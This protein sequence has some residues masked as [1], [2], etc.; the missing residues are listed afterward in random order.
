MVNILQIIFNFNN[1]YYKIIKLEQIS[2]WLVEGRYSY[3]IEN[4]LE[5]SSSNRIEIDFNVISPI[6]EGTYNVY[7]ATFDQVKN[8]N[9]DLNSC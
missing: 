7:V 5:I 4:F 8:V 6:N 2:C 3:V 9:I 1:I